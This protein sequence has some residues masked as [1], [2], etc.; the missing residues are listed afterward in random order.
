MSGQRRYLKFAAVL[1][2]TVALALSAR[3]QDT[4]QQDP[5]EPD[6]AA[7]SKPKP[8]ARGI[9]SI[10]DPNATV[11]NETTKQDWQPDTAP[12]TGLQV[13]GVGTPELAHSYWVPGL[14]YGST[15][16][17][18]PLGPQA[19]SSSG[20]Y[21]NNYVGA[22]LSLLKAWSRSQL[23]INYSGGGYFSTDS[24]INSGAY[25]QLSS[26]YTLQ[27]NRLQFQLF[28]F[29]SYIP[30]SQF[31]FANGTNLA[32]PGISGTLGPA[33]PGLGAAIIPNQNI[34]AAV[35][36]RY[37]N[38]FAAQA[39]YSLSRRSSL[40]FGGSF[41][42]LHFTQTGSV[43][44][45]MAIGTAGY[46]YAINK[47]SSIGLLYRFT[48]YHYTGEPQALGNHVVN[49]VYVK[50]INQ[51]LALSLFGGPQITTY[52]IPIGTATD[53]VSASGGATFTY[54]IPNGS[55]G[56]SY[57]HGLA[58]GGG[59]LVGSNM[60][61]VTFG[62]THL[63]GRVWSADVNLGYSRNSSLGTQT[64]APNQAFSDWFVGGGVSRPIGRNFNVAA[65]YT[66]RYESSSLSPCT[67][68]AC[69][70]NYT[71]NMVSVSLQWHTRPFVLP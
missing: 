20:W 18:R 9:P 14:E 22:D 58:N 7:P 50:K 63:I 29:F 69:S 5:Q 64:G 12:A 32:L 2:V 60:D 53:N 54:V 1:L 13:P 68:T 66:V 16:Q 26:G 67:G 15:I 65:T 37:S 44:N 52:R 33:V 38:A 31:G 3:A 8:A 21:A 71:Q 23:G 17:S 36:P 70:Y 62:F 61:Q 11:E 25:Q 41:G 42:L 40:T 6:T 34:Y 59:V 47:T 56:A 48:A 35:G 51:R 30:D 24:Q 57:F 46:N 43:D 10:S 39:T 45:D 27:T 55:L 19:T 49:F 28:D 4:S